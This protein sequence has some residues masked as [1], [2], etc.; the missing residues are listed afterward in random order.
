MAPP[1]YYAERENGERREKSSVGVRE[2][3]E[4]GV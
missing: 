1:G 3:M 4:K 2:G